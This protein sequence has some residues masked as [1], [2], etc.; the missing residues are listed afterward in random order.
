MRVY[1]SLAKSGLA[2]SFQNKNNLTKK[3]MSNKKYIATFVLDTRG[4]DQPVETL[5]EKLKGIIEAVGGKVESA[6]N[7]GVKEFARTPDRKF[8]SGIF[9]EIAFEGPATSSVQIKEKLSRDKTVN[10]MLIKSA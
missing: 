7:K 4:Y 5:I 9:V 1:W 6:E 2:F 10:R 3:T 8:A